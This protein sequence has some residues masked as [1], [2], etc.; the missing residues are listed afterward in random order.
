VLSTGSANA[1]FGTFTGFHNTTGANNAFF[2]ASSGSGITTGSNN[3]AIGFNTSMSSGDLS[4]ATAIGANAVV[5]QSDSLVLGN[6]ANVGIGTTTPQLPL[7]VV[8]AIKSSNPGT[9]PDGSAISFSSPGNNVG[10]IMERGNGAGSVSRRWDLLIADDNTFRIKHSTGVGG[11][12]LVITTTDK[13]GIGTASPSAELDVVG[14]TE[15]NGPTTL[16]ENVVIF[17]GTSGAALKA[18]CGSGQTVAFKCESIGG[19]RLFEVESDGT[20]HAPLLGDAIATYEDVVV[21][22][23]GEI[24]KAVSSRRYKDNIE[25][26]ADD[27]DLILKTELKQWTAK[28]DHDGPIGFGFIAEEIEELGLESLVI[29]NK[30]GQVESLK[31]RNIPLYTL[32][33]VKRHEREVQDLREELKTKDA[34]IVDLTARLDRLE[35]LVAAQAGHG[36][37]GIR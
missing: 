23:T 34:E 21:D 24:L 22:A 11:E 33:V 6:N 28:G 27:F 13:V 17:G 3:T 20:V 30:E 26:F 4:N 25:P 8:G 7:D 15:L 16:N 2:G 1:F 36:N 32:Q 31:F 18:R 29:Y 35:K 14:S 9:S 12:P 10:I 37:G 19:T 5:G